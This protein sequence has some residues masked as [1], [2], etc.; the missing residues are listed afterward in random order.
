MPKNS[1]LPTFNRLRAR[2]R[3]VYQGVSKYNEQ[4]GV[5]LLTVLLLVVAIT[6]V[7]GSMLA[8]QKISIRQYE[9]LLNQDKI[10]QDIR[11]AE[12]MAGALIAADAQVNDTDSL[13]D[14]WA[15]PIEPTSFGTHDIRLTIQDASSQFN[16][17]NLYHDGAVDAQQVTLFKRL[18]MQLGLDPSLA[19]AV[20]DWQDPDSEVSGQGGAESEEYVSELRS[21]GNPSIV[22]T[23]SIGN[24]PFVSVDEL[25]SVKGFTAESVNQLQPYITAFPYYLPINVNT[26]DPL[27]LSTLVAE[28][29]PEQFE[30]LVTSRQN[31]PFEDI[32][33]FL[34]QPPMSL[35]PEKSVSELKPFLDVQSHG[36]KVL[37]D[38]GVK[39]GEQESHRYATSYISKI[40][41]DT[42]DSSN[43]GENP[44]LNNASENSSKRQEF[45]IQPF[46][47]RLWT[48]RP[49]F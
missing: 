29:V 38:V 18:L 45:Q 3:E 17:N 20:L 27:L 44:A 39:N 32:E 24:Q 16:L 5:A 48:Y 13:Q 40:G 28:G 35:L 49:A 14:V 10:V 8:S 46:G 9:L 2:H 25:N 19:Y 37:I 34:Q 36:F 43:D 6:V 41:S 1:L 12:N 42:K 23:A 30:P 31:S 11:A 15:K 47:T 21:I 26:A 33:T 4:Q 7:A 22:S